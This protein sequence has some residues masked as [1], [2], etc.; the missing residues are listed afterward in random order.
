VELSSVDLLSLA[1]GK[2]VHF[3]GAGGAGMT[4]LAALV[5]AS[6]GKV[7][8][9]DSQDS[10][11]VRSLATAGAKIAIG[12][13]PIHVAECS[14]LIVTAA[15]PADHP[16]IEAARQA[17]IPV[18]KRAEALGAIVNDGFVIGI[19][20]T[21]GKTTTT[22]LTASVLAASD[23]DPTGLVGGHVVGWNGNLRLGNGDL[24]VVEADEYDRSFLR[25]APKVAAITTMEADHLDVFGSMEGVER[26]FLD[27]VRLVPEDGLIVGC[28]DDSGVGRLLPRLGRPRPEVMTYGLSAG[29][30][31]RADSIVANG[32]ATTFT[33]WERGKRIGEAEIR[34]AGLHNVR[35]A[36]PGGRL[37]VDRRRT[38]RL[39]RRRT[40]LRG[41]R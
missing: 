29:S 24:F 4:P 26:A 15:I 7:T 19:A 23:L 22:A 13:D 41:D 2:P 39:R 8:C 31:T 17:G 20:G 27:F 1:R 14:A 35:N 32:R 38:P 12:H 36:P 21:H 28:A 6:G 33:V 25:L 3:M 5:L 40:P 18:L 10:T 34:I 9:C 16:E 11:A 30:M 37:A